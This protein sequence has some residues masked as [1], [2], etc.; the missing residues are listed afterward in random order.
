M[1]RLVAIL[2]TALSSVLGMVPIVIGS[3][4]GKEI[5]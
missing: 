3:G 2:L 1:E 5:F 4:A